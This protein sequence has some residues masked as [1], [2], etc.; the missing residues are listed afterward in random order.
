MHKFIAATALLVA[1][2]GAA[3]PALADQVPAPPSGN[4]DNVGWTDGSGVGA[5]A[6]TSSDA[7]GAT[8]VAVRS[9][10][11]PVCTYQALDASES[12]TADDMAAHGWGPPRGTGSGAW[13]R[14]ICTGP[15]GMTSGVIVWGPGAAPVDPAALAQQALGYT[16]MPT[17]AVGMSPPPNREQLVNLTTFLWIDRAQWQPVS[18]SASAG[19]VTV[20]TTAAPERAVWS[21]GNGDS[22]TCNGPGEPYDASRSDADQPDPCRYVYRH[23]SAGQPNDAFIVTTTV[24]W[25]ITWVATGVPAGAPAAG[26]LGLVAR[27]SSVAVRVAEAQATNTSGT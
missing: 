8:P 12:A 18:A 3:S 14:K 7:N 2:I 1:L 9:G 17:P 20:V 19:G 11:A 24:Q 4:R 5:G 25:H 26:D 10:A 13:Y 15:N 16:P 27:S 23:S 22:V 6:Q 21:M